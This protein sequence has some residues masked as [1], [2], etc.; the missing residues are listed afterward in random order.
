M[1]LPASTVAVPGEYARHARQRLIVALDF[2]RAAAA[3]EA[4][5]QLEGLVQWFK[6]GLELYLAEG[7]SIIEQVRDR[8]LFCLS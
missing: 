3:L 8:R 1:S 4:V 6:I 5:H 7:N 2:P